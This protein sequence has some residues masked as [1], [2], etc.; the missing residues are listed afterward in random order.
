MSCDTAK[1]ETRV[2]VFSKTEG[3]RHKSIE[4]GVEAIRKLGKENGFIV[5]HSED[6][7]IINEDSLSQYNAVIFL[8]TTGDIFN[9]EQQYE[10]MRY[11]Q[12]GGGFV[13]IHAATDTEYKWPWYGELVGGYFNGHPPGIKNADIQK[14][15]D[16]HLSCAHLPD[17]WNRDDEYYNFKNLNPEMTVLLNLD[18]T[19][20]EGG[21]NGEN[22]PI[23][24]TRDNMFYT[25]LGHTEAS[26]S[27]ENF[28]KHIL[29]GILSVSKNRP[30]YN[31]VAVAPATNRF[32]KEVLE[33]NLDEPMELVMMPNN[34]IMYIQRKGEVRYYDSKK[35]TTETINQID[36]HTEFEDGLL[37]ITL[38]PNFEENK[39]VYL[40]YSPKIE[41]WTQYV[42]RFEFKDGKIDLSSEKIIIKIPVQREKCCH[43]AGGLE[44]DSHG[45]LFISAGDDTNPFESNG[46]SPSDDREGRAPFDA[47][48]SSSSTNDFR[49]GILRITPQDDGTYTIPEG[50]LFPATDST[51]AEIYVMGCR[52]PFRFFIDPKTDF[53]Y[54]GDV[55]PDA[56]K[57]NENR[58]PR[59]YDEVNQAREAGYFGWPLFIAD[60]IPYRAYDFGR[61]TTGEEF[62]PERPIN[63]SKFNTGKKVLPKANKAFIYYPYGE[64]EEFPLVGAGGRN[65]MAGFVYHYDDYPESE[66][67]LP[68]YYDGKLFTYDWIRG[69]FMATTMNEDGDFVS[70]ERFLPNHKFSNPTDIVINNDGNIYLLEYGT[71]WFSMNADARLVHLKFNGGNRPPVPEVEIDQTIG[72]APMT[73]SFDAGKSLDY[74]KDKISYTWKVGDEVIGK[75]AKLEHTFTEPGNYIVKLE[76]KDKAG[77]ISSKEIPLM[78]GNDQPKVNIDIK[79][80]KSFYFENEPINY[81]VSVADKEDGKIG[82]GI[83]PSAVAINIDYLE[84]GY[85]RNEIAMGHMSAIASHPGMKA[86]KNSDCY[87]CH[88]D[89]AKSI[90]PSYMDV[91]NKYRD[92][93]KAPGYLSQR[94]IE[95]GGGVWGE[96]AMAAHPQ[97]SSAEVLSMVEY[98]LDLKEKTDTDAMPIAGS[99]ELEI[100]EGKKKGGVFIMN[101]S[102]VDNGAPKTDPISTTETLVFRNSNLSAMDYD[103]K[104]DVKR[105]QLKAKDYSDLK[106]DVSVLVA[107]DQSHVLYKKL[108]FTEIQSI[109]LLTFL[110]HG[111]MAGGSLDLKLDGV[112]GK[113]IG[114]LEIKKGEKTAFNADVLKI[115]GAK[116]VHDLYVHF[117]SNNPNQPAFALQ[118][119][120]FKK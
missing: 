70:M 94:I 54:W 68:K 14:K 101:A 6:S 77:S 22:H 113:S 35:K 71:A 30:N 26:F 25:G 53:L 115:S 51:K 36:V 3:Y 96:Q 120:R 42:S 10:F 45:N 118:E 47:R 17:V 64:S 29:G 1:K 49:G 28:L 60:N 103:A 44:F 79:G 98:I 119:L 61:K 48:R 24:W 55:G 7:D 41:E 81:K 95:G 92:D 67:K 66:H 32:Q 23:A 117:K 112:N 97:L 65:A 33:M 82:E 21:T 16:T 86:M 76:V 105:E 13:G 107:D 83:D 18:E 93:K 104:E 39:W 37:G 8:S 73:A 52:N 34:D 15:N 99:Y 12:A 31:G 5:D 91:A 50:N 74:D 108:D 110:D 116:G 84:N 106:K 88:K 57:D 111:K 43:S 56:G 75:N 109:E 4:P 46:F 9:D 102:Y 2:L 63:N 62:N 11:Y 59:G 38:D 89:N 100:P 72:A 40:F 87:S 78:V 19:T 20:Y 27:E 85:D 80:N 114:S 69:W 90:G 58:G